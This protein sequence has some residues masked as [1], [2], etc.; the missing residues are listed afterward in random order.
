MFEPSQIRQQKLDEIDALLLKYRVP[1][2]DYCIRKT[3]GNVSAVEDLIQD[4]MLAACVHRDEFDSRS[5]EKTQHKWLFSIAR[6]EMFKY[7]QRKKHRIRTVRSPHSIDPFEETVSSLIM[8]L[9]HEALSESEADII[10]MRIDGFSY[11]EIAVKHGGT[12]VAM[13]KK[14]QRSIEKIIKYHNIN[15]NNNERKDHPK[16]D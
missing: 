5:S 6:T 8:D 16:E 1:L 11:K 3:H 10:Q 7:H 15:T 4:I 2:T 9:A 12:D 13:R 14:L